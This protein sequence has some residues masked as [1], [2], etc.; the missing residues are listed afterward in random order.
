M[1]TNKPR[2]HVVRHSRRVTSS[3]QKS[4]PRAARHTDN[5]NE[6]MNRWLAESVLHEYDDTESGKQDIRYKLLT[7]GK[8]PRKLYAPC[9]EIGCSFCDAEDE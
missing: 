3:V 8:V 7:D 5:F 6:A 2:G 1:A 4:S 9:G